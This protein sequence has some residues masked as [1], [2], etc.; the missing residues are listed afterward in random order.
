MSPPIWWQVWAV[1][2]TFTR[3]RPKGS[4][5]QSLPRVQREGFSRTAHHPATLP[6]WR[7]VGGVTVPFLAF[8]PTTVQPVTISPTQ[9][10]DGTRPPGRQRGSPAPP[11]GSCQGS[12]RRPPRATEPRR[13]QVTRSGQARAAGHQEGTGHQLG[14][15]A[16]SRPPGR[17]RSPARAGTAVG[18]AASLAAGGRVTVPFLAFTPTTVQPGTIRPAQRRPSTRPPGRDRPTRCR[19]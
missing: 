13:P 10:R 6:A 3:A 5:W 14:A 15:G 16:G 17:H 8:T 11:A 18:H 2:T 1:E 12:T 9:R 19:E 7:P 4:H